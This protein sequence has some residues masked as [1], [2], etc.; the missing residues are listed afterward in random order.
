MIADPWFY[1][2]A[3]P[4]V[5][6]TGVSKGGFG[7]GLG[8]LAVPVLALVVSP[9][10]AA[11]IM[12]P[13]LCLMDLFGLWAY[14]RHWHGGVLAVALPAA[15]VG[16]AAGTLSFR[17]LHDDAIR[18]L[19]G[20]IAVAFTLHHWLAGR[21][22]RAGGAS[23]GVPRLRGALWSAVAGFT[24]F[25]AHSGGPPFSVFLL[26][27]RLD[28][29]VFTGTAVVFFALVNYAKLLPYG[30][31][32][33]LHGTH[34]GASLALSPLAPLSIALGVWLH[35]RLSLAGFYRLAYGI[36]FV[37]GLK[38]LYEGAGLPLPWG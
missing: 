35:G 20:G 14:R 26:P 12:L 30:W 4:A 33:Q 17:W 23:P 28:K 13:V 25:V 10:E 15:L 16:I 24:S 7:T 9:T 31:L 36:V 5:L 37:A 18:L 34:L 3:V 2:A 1:A 27:L 21:A 8:I 11:A 22:A 32:G 29:S 19:V 38:L 6:I